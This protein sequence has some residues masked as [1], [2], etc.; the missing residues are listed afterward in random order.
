MKRIAQA[1]DEQMLPLTQ[2]TEGNPMAL[3]MA[4]DHVAQGD[5]LDEIVEALHHA[6][7]TANDIFS[8]LFDHAWHRLDENARH[9]LQVV[10]FFG[11]RMDREALGAAAG[12]TDYQLYSAR[13]QLVDL[14][15]LDVLDEPGVTPQFYSAHSLT[16]AFSASHLAQS[17]E[18]EQEARQRWVNWYL[19]FT[20]KY[21]GWDWSEW[22]LHFDRVESEWPNIQALLTWCADSD[23]NAFDHIR[24]F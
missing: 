5:T 4:L 11:E 10:P 9:L 7:Q 2:V 19:E 22:A 21:G 24:T 12:L 8:Y 23:E 18:W 14:S 6:R 15:L 16:R 1:P 13:N 20:Q 17:P 3:R